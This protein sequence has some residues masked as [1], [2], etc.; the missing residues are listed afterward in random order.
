M[1]QYLLADEN[2]DAINAHNEQLVVTTTK[3]VGKASYVS[4]DFNRE[5]EF[6]QLDDVI[7]G[8]DIAGQ[9]ARSIAVKLYGNDDDVLVRRVRSALTFGSPYQKRLRNGNAVVA[10]QDGTLR[11][12][13][14]VDEYGAL[15]TENL[16][17]EGDRLKKA[18]ALR[19]KRM[20]RQAAAAVDKVPELAEAMAELRSERRPSPAG[21]SA[22]QSSGNASGNSFRQG[23]SSRS[24]PPS[25]SLSRS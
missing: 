20:D 2:R 18:V 13:S 25:G 9:T 14:T 17:A 11:I 4:H 6:R 3:T 16:A 1:N 21:T 5:E 22:R 8:T 7:G 12:T 19:T 23:C 24:S 10:R 15:V